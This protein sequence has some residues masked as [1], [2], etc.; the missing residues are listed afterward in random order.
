MN[1]TPIKVEIVSLSD[2]KYIL[3]QARALT[4]PGSSEPSYELLKLDAPIGDLPSVVLCFTTPILIRE[5]V[6]SL[7]DIGVWSQSTRVLDLDNWDIVE[8]LSKEEYDRI[9]LDLKSHYDQELK[10]KT[11]DMARMLL[12]TAHCSKYLV[13][14]SL[15]TLIKLY[16]YAHH[17]ESIAIGSAKVV[18]TAFREQLDLV[19]YELFNDHGTE[20]FRELLRSINMVEILHSVSM[21]FTSSGTEDSITISCMMPLAMRAQI[22]RH[23]MFQVSDDFKDLFKSDNALV[24]PIRH[25]IRVKMTAHTSI[26]REV[27]RTRNCWLAQGELW[28]PILREVNKIMMQNGNGMELPLPCSDGTCTYHAECMKRVTREEPGLPCPRHL[29]LR[30]AMGDTQPLKLFSDYFH[31]DEGTEHRTHDNIIND[32]EEYAID[33]SRPQSYWAK[34]ILGVNSVLKES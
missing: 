3:Q 1:L 16:K 12:P 33:S 25:E 22:I 11:Q 34:Q 7:R 15:R 8:G 10:T 4:R 2:W 24:T 20:F 6:T 17:L 31:D 5:V 23:R 21:P 19:C 9:D 14:I 32:L 13:R 27:A 30:K 18:C 29:L 28:A 26:W